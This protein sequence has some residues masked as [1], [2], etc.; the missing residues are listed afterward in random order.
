MEIDGGRCDGAL[1]A[2]YI[3]GLRRALGAVLRARACCILQ[4]DGHV[5]N[6]AEIDRADYDDHKQRQRQ[7]QFNE[8]ATSRRSLAA[9]STAMHLPRHSAVADFLIGD[10]DRPAPTK[11]LFS[12]A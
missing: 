1:H 2:R 12:V 3:A 8:R 7:R 5:E 11:S 4:L 9:R 6:T 10:P